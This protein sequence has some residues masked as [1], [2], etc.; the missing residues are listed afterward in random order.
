MRT[1]EIS[2][3]QI[4]L[5]T[6]KP[7][8]RHVGNMQIL[9]LAAQFT[10]RSDS[11]S[12]HTENKYNLCKVQKCITNFCRRRR[13]NTGWRK[14]VAAPDGARVDR[15]IGSDIWVVAPQDGTGAA[16]LWLIECRLGH[17]LLRAEIADAGYGKP[18]WQTVIYSIWRGHYGCATTT[19][20]GT[21]LSLC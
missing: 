12:N 21:R 3:K 15:A 16:K 17:A 18:K 7:G 20:V 14:T 19:S 11:V 13:L 2:A 5:K 8:W 6:V 1:T 4:C 9:M 10:E